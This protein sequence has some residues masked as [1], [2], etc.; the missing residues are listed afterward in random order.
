MS[1]VIEYRMVILIIIVQQ[2][3]EIY[4]KLYYARFQVYK[5]V[6]IFLNYTKIYVIITSGLK[7]TLIFR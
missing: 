4:K 2:Y 6:H 3:D 7:T 5:K 1:V